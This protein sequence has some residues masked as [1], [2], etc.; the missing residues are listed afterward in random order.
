MLDA[1]GKTYIV[2]RHRFLVPVR[3]VYDR[4]FENLADISKACTAN[5]QFIGHVQSA[6]SSAG[7]F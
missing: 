1:L 4:V 7:R 3:R 2:N 6:A 5:S